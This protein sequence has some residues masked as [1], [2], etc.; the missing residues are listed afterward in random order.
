[1]IQNLVTNN[2]DHVFA[3]HDDAVRAQFDQTSVVATPGTDASQVANL[4]SQLESGSLNDGP[5]SAQPLLTAG[6][7][8][9][10]NSKA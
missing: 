1:M 9:H 3:I 5:Q 10:I 4:R 2:S 6:I 8:I 7:S